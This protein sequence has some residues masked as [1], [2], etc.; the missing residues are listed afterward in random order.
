MTPLKKLSL[1]CIVLL[2]FFGFS[3]KRIS[4]DDMLTSIPSGTIG[5]FWK[6]QPQVGQVVLIQNPLD[7]NSQR[8]GRII[9]IGG[10]RISFQ[11]GSFVV[12][13][14]RIQQLDMGQNGDQHRTYQES[15]WIND[16][17]ISW[18]INS[19]IE[20]IDWSMPERQLAENTI[21][22]ACDNR[23]ECIDSRWWGPVKTDNIVGTL[24]MQINKP[25]ELHPFFRFYPLL[26]L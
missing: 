17:E 16:Q 19:R 10:Q 25:T 13:G 15:I 1:L 9:A 11:K 7:A 4:T 12:D 3:G 21:F 6:S 22:V 5:W 24:R 8:L 20:A 23:S 14:K 2:F 18:L 26:S